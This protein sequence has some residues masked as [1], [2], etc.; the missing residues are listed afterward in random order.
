MLARSFRQFFELAAVGRELFRRSSRQFEPERRALP[1]LAV[2]ADLA[3]V[4]RRQAT[5]KVQ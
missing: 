5:T 1:R 3:D 4:R 2:Y